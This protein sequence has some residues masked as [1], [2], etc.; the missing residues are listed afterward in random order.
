GAPLARRHGPTIAA[1]PDAIDIALAGGA[2]LHAD[3]VEQPE[4]LVDDYLGQADDSEFGNADKPA[5]V[6][7]LGGYA[8]VLFE[9]G[10]GRAPEGFVA[11]SAFFAVFLPF[12]R[13]VGNTV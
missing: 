1:G 4:I 9:I 7:H 2:H 6:L 10:G 13:H 3:H 8:N 5:E 12:I 11:T